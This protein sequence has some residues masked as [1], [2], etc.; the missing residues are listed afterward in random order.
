MRLW[1][2]ANIYWLTLIAYSSF[3][4]SSYRY[5]DG[6]GINP[7]AIISIIIAI[8]VMIAEFQFAWYM[9]AA[10]KTYKPRKNK[11]CF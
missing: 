10:E 4:L 3:Y 9:W 11:S 8:S 7:L 6:R 1:W 2:A 5:E